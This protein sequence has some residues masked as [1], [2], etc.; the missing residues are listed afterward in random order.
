M[1]K[2]LLDYFLLF[3]GYSAVGL[4]S[5]NAKISCF[6]LDNNLQKEPGPMELLHAWVISSAAV[7]FEKFI[8]N[9]ETLLCMTWV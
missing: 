8:D 9:I 4:G 5:I 2:L 7:N 1:M 3:L 6:E